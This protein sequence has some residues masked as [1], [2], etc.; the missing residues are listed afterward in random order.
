MPSRTPLTI[1][2]REED[3]ARKEKRRAKQR[4]DE[5]VSEKSCSDDPPPYE[6]IDRDLS[7][8]IERDVLEHA[9]GV[10]WVR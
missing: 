7:Q 8:V 10:M 3:K 5:D 2:T 6:A 9:P 4:D 1:R